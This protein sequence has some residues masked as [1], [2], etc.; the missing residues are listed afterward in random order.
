VIPG[1]KQLHAVQNGLFREGDELVGGR[2]LV[3]AASSKCESRLS[4]TLHH[5]G[6]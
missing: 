2:V 5:Y 3:Q 1:S 6:I 4:S